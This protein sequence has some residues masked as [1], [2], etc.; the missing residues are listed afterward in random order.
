MKR[1]TPL[2]LV[3]ALLLPLVS[4][5]EEARI[6]IENEL[7]EARA[8]N[9][10]KIKEAE[11][12]D[13][14]SAQPAEVE[15]PT[16]DGSPQ[17]EPGSPEN[18]QTND[19]AP[20]G[21]EAGNTPDYKNDWDGILSSEYLVRGNRYWFES[22]AVKN[23]KT[24]SMPTSYDLVRGECAGLCP[25]PLCPHSDPSVCKYV[26]V[27][28]STRF[29]F[30]D[31]HTL[32][33]TRQANGQIG[34]WRYDLSADKAKL[35]YEAAGGEPQLIGEDGGVV[36]FTE[37]KQQFVGNRAVWQ[38]V[39]SGIDV[40]TNKIV[41]ERTMDEAQILFIRDGVMWLNAVRTIRTVE[42]ASGK[43]TDLC[44]LDN[45]LGA[46]YYDTKDASFWFNTLNQ[47]AGTG[48][49]WVLRDGSL[50][51]VGLPADE[52]YCFHLTN[53]KICYSPYDPV[54][55]G[56]NP[57]VGE[58]WDYAGGKIYAVDRENPGGK[59]ELIYDAEGKY[60]LSIATVFGYTV[61]GDRLLFPRV[62]IV[63]E[64]MPIPDEKNGGFL[65]DE[66]TGKWLL[67]KFTFFDLSGNLP[68]V[69]VDLTTGEEEI[70][71]FD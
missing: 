2:L 33:W 62:K 59:A 1:L 57:S 5:R 68:T 52:I 56:R 30:A 9:E 18:A 21:T 42:L 69:H 60:I 61:F 31:D 19:T 51:K 15:A 71:R 49:L 38:Q 26:S 58:T 55:I 25:D 35:V 34:I 28:S 40:K 43:T 44:T 50:K 36:Y 3:L 17:T 4:C 41:Y 54:Y 63:T 6:E 8:A 16:A 14:P 70:I 32:Y 11:K 47:Q 37:L 48:S 29:V 64:T 53:S 65:I 23:G 12:T 46:W 67:D 7:A 45:T 39:L 10:E 13:G 24:V 27:N 20:A 22:K 66:T